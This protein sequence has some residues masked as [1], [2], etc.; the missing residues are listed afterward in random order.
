LFSK[1]SLRLGFGGW[2]F[3]EFTV[4]SFQLTSFSL[5]QS[6]ELTVIRRQKQEVS[7]SLQDTRSKKKV[8]R[9]KWKFKGIEF[10]L[11]VKRMGDTG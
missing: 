2:D 11:N 7:R 4:H 3:V 8:K 1:Y 9:L 5:Q 6:A 10:K